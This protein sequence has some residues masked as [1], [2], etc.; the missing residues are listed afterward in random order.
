ML[1]RYNRHILNWL[2]LWLYT[3]TM[4]NIKLSPLIDPSDCGMWYNVEDEGWWDLKSIYTTYLSEVFV[5]KES[6]P[7]KLW[8]LCEI[9]PPIIVSP[10]PNDIGWKITDVHYPYKLVDLKSTLLGSNNLNVEKDGSPVL[11]SLPVWL[12]KAFSHK[13]CW[14]WVK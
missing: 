11:R 13:P 10:W 7:P 2:E 8:Y 6:L 3:Y 9:L 14:L 5:L 1:K 12:P 4:Y